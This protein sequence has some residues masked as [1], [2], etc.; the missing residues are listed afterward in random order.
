MVRLGALNVGRY[1]S[2]HVGGASYTNW[3]GNTIL[4]GK[5]G[6]VK[7]QVNITAK[8]WSGL[9]MCVEEVAYYR[10]SHHHAWS[11]ADEKN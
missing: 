7:R 6:Y 3:V 2:E 4:R 8:T 1:N 11:G 10:Q 5:A 9:V